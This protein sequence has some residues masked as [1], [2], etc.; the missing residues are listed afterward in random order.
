[1]TG[2]LM[3]PIAHSPRFPLHLDGG[4]LPIA[5]ATEGLASAVR[6][7]PG[8]HH[9]ALIAQP[10]MLVIRRGITRMPDKGGE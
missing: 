3:K 2:P 6:P 10:E 7:L 1:M 4:L 8:I 9:R 5:C